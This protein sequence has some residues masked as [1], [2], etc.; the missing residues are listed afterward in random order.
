MNM[1]KKIVKIL[2]LCIM[3]FGAII[4]VNNFITPNLNSNS[5]VVTTYHPEDPDCYGPPTDCND[6]TKDPL[7]DY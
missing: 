1:I 7:P 2:L 4:V 5:F 3:I 6:F